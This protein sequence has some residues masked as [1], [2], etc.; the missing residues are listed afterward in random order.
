MVTGGAKRIG[1]AMALDLARHGWDV[2]VNYSA[3]ADA[4]AGLVEEIRAMGRVA[5]AV[6]GDLLDPAQVTALVP[7]AAD[8]LG[9]P[10]T[11]LVN[12]A[13]IFEHDTIETATGES[14]ERHVGSN[15]R[16]PV[17][18][19]QAFAAQ[20]PDFLRDNSGE[21]VAQACVVNMVDQR[22]R[23]LTPEFLTYTI[24]KAGLWTFTQTAAQ[25]LAPRIRVNAIGPGPTVQG[26]RQKPEHFAAQRKS[27]ILERGSNPEE[28]CATLQYILSMPAL[29]GQLLCLDGGQHLIWRTPGV[30]NIE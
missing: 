4:A 28:I 30:Q 10:L 6:H 7:A 14:W 22:V 26:T 16:A 24:A 13:S 3:S 2:A 8:G 9:R 27:T 18:L 1:R 29:T 11:L 23:A 5:V 20:A 21:P 12:N 15:L 17:F 19:T 25:A